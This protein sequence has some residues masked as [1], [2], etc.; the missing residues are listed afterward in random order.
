MAGVVAWLLDV[1]G[2]D[3]VVLVVAVLFDIVLLDLM[4][5]LSTG[6]KVTTYGVC[7]LLGALV[8]VVAE[9]AEA[10]LE[11]TVLLFVTAM[12]PISALVALFAVLDSAF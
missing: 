12:T 4:G 3:V 6:I 11:A 8:L 2:A 1:D 10:L 7:G 5:M 9:L